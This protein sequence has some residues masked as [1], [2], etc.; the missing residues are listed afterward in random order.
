MDAIA[1]IHS[2]GVSSSQ[3][4]RCRTQLNIYLQKF[5]NRLKG[6]NRVYITQTVR[7]LD[8]LSGFLQNV[9]SRGQQKEFVVNMSEL[10]AGKGVDQI[11][12]YKLVRYLQESKL[13]RKVEGYCTHAE[14]EAVS[15]DG[16]SEKG[17]EKE[18][19]K[20]IPV[21]TH[22]Q[23]F[24]LTLTN[25]SAEG[26]IIYTMSDEKEAS[27]KYMLLDPTHHFQEIVEQARSVILAGG[28]MSPVGYPN[29]FS[30]TAAVLMPGVR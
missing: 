1:G 3:L 16:S 22:L 19:Q 24:L 7:L 5:R 17:Q 28:T 29:S 9:A 27:L 30:V 25:P 6:K 8:S 26:R 4:Q 12:L 23:G 18:K 20:S 13:A 14:Q 15:K 2:V 21:L 10:M 11:N